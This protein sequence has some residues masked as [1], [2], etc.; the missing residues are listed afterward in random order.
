MSYVL[1]RSITEPYKIVEQKA[2]V[3][4]L[5][6]QR[7]DQIRQVAIQYETRHDRFPMT[8]DTLVMFAGTDSAFQSVRSQLL[9][10]LPVDSLMYSPRTGKMFTYTAND[11]SRVKTYLLVDPDSDDRIGTLDADIT[12]LNAASWE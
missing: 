12:L 11:T 8:L 3:T 6:R 4:Q 1:F 2:R 10:G 5:T 9:K 7:M